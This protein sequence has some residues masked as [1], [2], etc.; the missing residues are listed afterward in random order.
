MTNISGT[1]GAVVTL[2]GL[3]RYERKRAFLLYLN[4]AWSEQGTRMLYYY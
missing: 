3:D 1:D 4:E 2:N